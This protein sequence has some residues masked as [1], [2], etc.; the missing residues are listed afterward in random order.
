MLAQEVRKKSKPIAPA[1]Q[2]NLIIANLLFQS[3]CARTR[4]AMSRQNVPNTLNRARNPLN[5]REFVSH[6]Q[7]IV[8]YTVGV[9]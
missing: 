6:R 3:Y 7:S 4:N 5:L 2:I 1:I 8:A 9:W